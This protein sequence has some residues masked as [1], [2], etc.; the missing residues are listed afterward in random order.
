MDTY[1]EALEQVQEKAATELSPDKKLQ[2][3]KG[4]EVP[5]VADAFSAEGALQETGKL[6][7]DI[8]KML[9]QISDG[10][11]GLVAKYQKIKEAIHIKEKE[12]K[13]LYEK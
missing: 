4:R 8:G 13:E 12:L 9:T 10:L 11:E 7:L 3:K 1:Q 5:E 6:R 2:E